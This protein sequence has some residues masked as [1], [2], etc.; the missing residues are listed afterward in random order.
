MSFFV[1]P[2]QSITRQLTWLLCTCAVYLLFTAPAIAQNQQQLATG[3]ERDVNRYRWTA[4]LQ[5]RQQIKNWQFDATNRFSSDAFIL[6]NNLLSFRDE[7]QLSWMLD[8]QEDKLSA[9]PRFKGRLAWYSQSR[10]LSQEIYAF[11]TLKLL[12]VLAFEPA[13]G[14]AM[15]Q[16]PGANREDGRAPLQSDAGPAFGGQL[17][18]LPDKNSASNIA[19]EAGGNL[20]LI[21]PRRG[22]SMRMKGQAERLFA[23][24]RLGSTFSYSNARRDAY[25]AI[26]FLNR[27][28]D[29][30]LLSQTIEATTSDTLFVG[31]ELESP[32]T[33]SLK[34]TSNID[35]TA[36]NRKIRTFQAPD[37]SIFFD[38]DFNRRTVDAEV[39]LLYETRRLV[40]HLTMLG[41]AEFE[42]RQLANRDELPP[43][44]ATQKGDLLEQADYDRSFFTLRLRNQ[45][46]LTP[47]LDLRTES[48]A[49]ILRHDTPLSNQ[50]D[51]D[52]AFFNG[53]LGMQYR[54]SP[55]LQANMNVFGSYYHTVYLKARRSAENNVQRTLR[56]RPTIIW[57]PAQATYFRVTSEVRAT[58]TVDDFVLEGRR[59]TDQSAREL[60]YESEYKQDLGE[61]FHLHVTGGFSDLRLGRFLQDSFAEI[62]FDTLQTYSGWVR[63]RSEGRLNSELGVRVFTRT[64]FERANT[65]RY[66]R[67]DENGNFVVDETGAVLRSTVTRQGRRWIEQIGPTFAL[68]LPMRR[69]SAI[70]LDGWLNFQR[71]RQTL[72][73]DLPEELA[74]HIQREAQRGTLKTI[75]NVALSVIWNL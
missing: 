75:P 59:P 17:R 6:F 16:R 42:Q 3:F 37:Q 31:L 22:R 27:D 62:P 39:G 58:Y 19:I 33:K 74:D 24:T 29:T 66:R 18:F 61:G 30:N 55:Y 47:K 43:V 67:I 52:E 21:N 26:S 44:Q 65:V 13:V 51:R 8:R 69:A 14:F 35:F 40:S 49:N 72:Y 57:T 45:I 38:T 48:T 56:L 25:Q 2:S 10:V 60:R 23:E 68:V 5:L 70:R 53:L 11:T 28:T 34:L 1:N 73:G 54:I 7:N 36:N 50:D 71:I 63:I 20:Q 15:D 46:A 9:I 41:G 12:D 64:D 4:D 32:L